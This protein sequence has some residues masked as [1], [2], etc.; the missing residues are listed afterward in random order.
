[1]YKIY[2]ITKRKEW[3]CTKNIDR[4]LQKLGYTIL[5][6]DKIIEINNIDEAAEMERQLNLEYGYGWNESQD[7][8]RVTKMGLSG[9]KMGGD[10]NVENGNIYKA[11]Q[12]SVEVRTG[13]K[14]SD[15][16]KMKMKLAKLGKTSP[17]KGKIY[18]K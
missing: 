7:Y 4:R 10:K 6:V 5:D 17:K 16:T 8:R 12:R 14:H 11:Q 13:T 18:K 3:G 15:E 2:H 1:M 9:A